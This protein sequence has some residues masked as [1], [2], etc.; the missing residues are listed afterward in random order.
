[1]PEFFQGFLKQLF[2]NSCSLKTS[3]Q[4]TVNNLQIPWLFLPDIATWDFS[5]GPSSGIGNNKKEFWDRTF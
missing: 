1:M 5:N 3:L 2:K 4:S